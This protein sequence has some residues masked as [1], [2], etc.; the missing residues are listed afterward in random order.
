MTKKRPH[1][2][3]F[4][5]EL[6]YLRESRELSLRDV[7]A[8]TGISDTMIFRYEHGMGL[9]EM[10]WKHLKALSDFYKWDLVDMAKK[11][12]REGGALKEKAEQA[13]A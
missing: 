7:E 8:E 9:L 4:S 12:G 6:K 11:A 10:S 2:E 1:F 3:T 5:E 13:G